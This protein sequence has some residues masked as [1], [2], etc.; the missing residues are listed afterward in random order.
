MSHF[1]IFIFLFLFTTGCTKSLE[2]FKEEGQGVTRSLVQELQLVR[3]KDDLQNAS[4]RI[5]KVFDKM[6]DVMISAQQYHQTHPN[7]ES[8]EFHKDDLELSD[9]LRM[10]LNRLYLLENGKEIIEKCQENALQRLEIS[11]KRS[12]KK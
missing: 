10:E 7:L 4:P 12:L 5:K 11:K 2:D 3:T 1:P 8:I 6:V 9:R